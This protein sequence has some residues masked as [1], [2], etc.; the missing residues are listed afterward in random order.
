ML[1]DNKTEKVYKY[2]EKYTDNDGIFDIVTGYFTVGALSYFYNHINNNIKKFRFILGDIVANEEQKNHTIN[3]LNENID[4]ETTI[5]LNKLAKE[6]VKFL[7]QNKVTIKV[8]EPN[9]CHAKAYIYKDKKDERLNYFITGSSNLTEA[10]IGLKTT[11]NIELNIGET[12]DNAQ[13]QTLFKWFDE[14]W[15]SPS[16]YLDKTIENNKKQN[17]KKYLIEQIEQ[18][19]ITYNPKD[20]YY[21]IL[22]ELFKDDVLENNPE[23]NRELGKLENTKIYTTLYDFQKTGVLSIIKMLQKYD[24]AILADA[25]GLGKTWSGLGVI[26]FFQ[27]QGYETILLAPKKLQQNWQQYL[28]KRNSLFE[29]DNFDYTIRFHT[30]LFEKRLEKDGLTIKD[31]FQSDKPKLLVIDESHNLRNDKSSRYQFLMENLLQKNQNIKILLLS[32][33]PINNHLKDIRN[34]FNLIAK[35]D[36][37][38]FLKNLNISSLKGVFRKTVKSFNEWEEN[39]KM[40]EFIKTLPSEF[41]NLTD[42]L[43]VARTRKMIE[44]LSFPIKEKPQN[45]YLSPKISEYKDITDFHN[46]LPPKLT[47]YKP[48]FYIEQDEKTDV[49]HNEQLRDKALVKLIYMLLT[50]RFESSWQSF[51]DTLNKV[52]QYHLEIYNKANNYK[53]TKTDDKIETDIEIEEIND[54]DFSI[55]KREISLSQIEEN[56]QLDNFITD[57]E[58][59]IKYMKNMVKVFSLFKES[60]KQENTDISQDIKLAKLIK[61]LRNKEKQNNKKVIIFT[62][63]SDTAHYLFEELTKRKFDKIALV[64]GQTKHYETILE[65]FA[66]Y[67]K[68]YKEKQ[69]SDFNGNSYE[70]WLKW[71]KE[72]DN[73]IQKFLDNQIDILIATDVLSEGQNLQDADM[74]INYDIHWNPVRI[75]QRM[76]RIDRIGSPNKIIYGVNFW[77]SE[78]INEYLNLQTRIETK[79]KTM[80]V[81]GSEIDKNFTDNLEDVFDDE[82]DINQKK[83][84]LELLKT[85]F[86][87]IET[88]EMS[89]GFNDLSL[90]SFRQDFYKEFKRTNIYENMPNGVFSGFETDLLKGEFI[91]AFLQNR[92]NKI[93]ELVC[94]D[95]NSKVVFQNQKEILEFLEKHNNIDKYSRK[96]DKRVDDND[97]KFILELQQR[98]IKWAIT[99][100][101]TEKVENGKVKKIAGAKSLDFINKL[102]SGNK[103]S[104]KQLKKSNIKDEFDYKNYDLIVWYLIKGIKK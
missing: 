91:V 33:T 66:P 90:E 13:F 28:K 74:V 57:L 61:L 47:A 100:T 18:I 73:L 9:F 1:I 97:E 96:I 87:D 71:I 76:G 43:V 32:A 69:W 88:N 20:L 17:F 45:I 103:N 85:S 44:N 93:F 8:L 19:F 49:L 63:Y 86:D 4:I 12:G 6:A 10:G 53:I 42:S 30:D 52:Y 77:P 81:V 14:L 3:L 34:Q 29:E 58:E 5:K 80:K 98:L 38:A 64:E 82:V 104:T 99:L 62:A 95:E 83:K 37:N 84:M 27:L 59:D 16:A 56:N 102:K 41:I 65:R 101:S 68:L 22:F 60:I 23:F 78:D 15:K 54:E 94:I 31:Y 36:D 48:S 2:I 50:K 39:T 24:G 35:D 92:K 21:K 40:S 11:N 26:K 75:I 46:N 67:T 55:G 79:M 51:Y 25:V 7:E 72:K 89:L 70:E